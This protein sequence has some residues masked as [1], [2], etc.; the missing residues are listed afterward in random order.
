[1]AGDTLNELKQANSHLRRT[2]VQLANDLEDE[3]LLVRN[4]MGTIKNY[5]KLLRS[6][7]ESCGQEEDTVLVNEHSKRQ[8]SWGILCSSIVLLDEE[9]MELTRTVTRMLEECAKYEK[10]HE[11]RS[12]KLCQLNMRIERLDSIVFGQKI[13][14]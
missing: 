3:K 2:Q 4:L 1:M 5:E 6:E 8:D 9:C 11:Y 10:L 12:K 7:R 14:C 13:E